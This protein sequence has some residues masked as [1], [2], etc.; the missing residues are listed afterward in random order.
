MV[1]RGRLQPVELKSI[2]V[3]YL[4]RNRERYHAAFRFAPEYYDSFEI[5]SLEQK[6]MDRQHVCTL[7]GLHQPSLL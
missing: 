7:P 1:R 2:H 6:P 4:N 3:V 5:S